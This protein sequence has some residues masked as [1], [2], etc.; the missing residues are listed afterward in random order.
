MAT[1]NESKLSLAQSLLAIGDKHLQMGQIDKAIDQYTNAVVLVHESQDSEGKFNVYRSLGVAYRIAGRLDEATE[2]LNISRAIGQAIGQANLT[3]DALV[4]LG[5]V[6]RA[7][8]DAESARSA[9]SLAL[10]LAEETADTA[11]QIRA[12]MH[13]GDIESILDQHLRAIDYHQ[14]ALD[15]ATASGGRNDQASALVGI[16]ALYDALGEGRDAEQAF[17]SAVALAHDLGDGRSEE[18]WE[19]KLGGI[20]HGLEE[21][22][23]AVAS[24][25]RAAE[26]AELSG[27]RSDLA[28]ALV[29]QA[30]AFAALDRPQEALG[31]ADQA[32]VLSQKLD[33]KGLQGRIEMLVGL[34]YARGGDHVKSLDYF[35]HARKNLTDAGSLDLVKQI[36]AH[37]AGAQSAS[38]AAGGRGVGE[39]GDAHLEAVTVARQLKNRPA[40]AAALSSLASATAEHGKIQE[41]ISLFQESLEIYREV[42]NRQGESV[43]LSNLGNLFAQYGQYKKAIEHY[44]LALSIAVENSDSASEARI[45][46]NL[47]L[48][49][50]EQDH[51]M[52]AIKAL[53]EAA[54]I[55]ESLND[56]EM[57][58]YVKS[59]LDEM[60]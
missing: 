50:N 38:P 39:P 56:Q 30:N 47:G 10:A 60:G 51:Q 43:C 40:E 16:G 21:F 49:L 42:N 28:Q 20:R 37:I 45:L 3:A 18:Q 29:G 5:E 36:D 32:L 35:E 27:R 4:E 9:F 2:Y 34:I 22:E 59:L 54:D 7:K 44:K 55:F 15:V 24:F 31:A 17:A 8:E 19:L 48:A 58:D 23:K 1:A 52:D 11:L 13:L 46:T 12:L 57:L 14:K 53:R 41:A 6:S 25:K 26:L 33:D